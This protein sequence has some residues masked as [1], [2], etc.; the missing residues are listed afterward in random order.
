ME[1]KE[2]VCLSGR[3]CESGDILIEHVDLPRM[4][5]GN[6][7]LLPTA[8]AYCLPMASNYNLVPRPGVIIVDKF[9]VQ[10]MER[11]ETYNDILA[12]YPMI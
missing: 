1:V 11:R 10:I 5:E 12:R 8:G 7:V 2:T 6:L 4:H 9:G 3:Y